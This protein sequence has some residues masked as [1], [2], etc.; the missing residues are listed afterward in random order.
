M[1]KLI[2]A[3][4]TEYLGKNNELLTKTDLLRIDYSLQAITGELFKLIILLLIFSNLKQLPL[5]LLC[6]IILITTRTLIGGFHCKRFASCLIITI[7]YFLLI[8]VLSISLPF[9]NKYA[10][11]ISYVVSFIIIFIYAPCHNAK[12][13][14]KNKKRLKILSLTSITLWYIFVFTLKNSQ[15]SNCIFLSILIQTIQ[16]II[17]ERRQL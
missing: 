4:I 5:F 9:L 11:I 13:P 17:I 8:I 7:I 12:R 6:F 2:S 3:T 10:Y 16:L 15:V 1:I 14:I